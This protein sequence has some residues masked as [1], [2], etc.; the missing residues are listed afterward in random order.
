MP[1]LVFLKESGCVPGSFQRTSSIYED[2]GMTVGDLIIIMEE[3]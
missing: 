3:V 2:H 1:A